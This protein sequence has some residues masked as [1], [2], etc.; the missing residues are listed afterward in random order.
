[1]SA[2]PPATAAVALA[3]ETLAGTPLLGELAALAGEYLEEPEALLARELGYCDTIYL[4]RDA[5]GVV[6]SF[7]LAAWQTLALPEEPEVP[8]IYLGLGAH[9]QVEQRGAMLP[10]LERFYRDALAFAQ[11]LGQSPYVWGTTATASGYLRAAAHLL[12]LEP[13]R[14][15]RFSDRGRALAIAIRARLGLPP[16]ASHPFLLERLEPDLVYRRKERA[17]IGEVERESALALFQRLGLEVDRGDQLLFVGR[18]P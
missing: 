6:S 1:V 4:T 2:D 18:L 17:R 13:A 12:D 7:L 16:G 15:G 10:L 5:A 3:T 11:K 9:R 14:D 8:A